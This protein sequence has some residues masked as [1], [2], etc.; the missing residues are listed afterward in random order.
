MRKGQL[1]TRMAYR[2]IKPTKNRATVFF[3]EDASV[4]D[5]INVILYA[6]KLSQQFTERFAPM[7]LAKSERET[8]R[9]V[10]NFV[11]KN[12]RYVEDGARNEIV[13]SPGKTWHDKTG[14]C[15]SMSV[16][17]GALLQNLEFDYFYRVAFYDP[18]APQQGHIY[19]IAKTSTGEEIVVDA[20]HYSFDHEYS[21]W[22]KQDYKPGS[23]AKINGTPGTNDNI[24]GLIALGG[25]ALLLLPKM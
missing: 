13:K 11:K 25:L 16:M 18:S 1:H 4:K 17:V 5:I 9:N 12:I 20:V 7:L 22:K 23:G 19:P 2:Y 10:W 24:M 14:D 15:K 8:L 3:D 6:D 21:Y